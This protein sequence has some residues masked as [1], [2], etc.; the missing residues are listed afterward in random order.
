[1]MC[2]QLRATDFVSAAVEVPHMPTNSRAAPG[3]FLENTHKH[4]H[5]SKSENDDNVPSGSL[6][7]VSSSTNL[8]N[9]K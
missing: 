5:N 6:H 7:V 1:M 4:S 2:H 9:N 8:K 3:L